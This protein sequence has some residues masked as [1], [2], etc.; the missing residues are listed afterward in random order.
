MSAGTIYSLLER[1]VKN[2]P[3]EVIIEVKNIDNSKNV[4]W[5]K[6]KSAQVKEQVDLVA[7]GLV[8]IGVKKGDAVAIMAHTS[9]SWVVI[10]FALLS[11]GALSIPIYETSSVKQ[12]EYILS[13]SAIK[14]V[15]TEDTILADRVKEASANLSDFEG[16]HIIDNT[17]ED[18][19]SLG[20][21]AV[22]YL[23]Q[24]GKTFDDKIDLEVLHQAVSPDDLAT[25]VYTSGS[26]GN[27]KGV[28]LTHQNFFSIVEGGLEGMPEL[29]MRD[30]A[31]LLLFLPLAH[32]FARY[33]EFV[34]IGG[35]IC[36]GLVSDVSTLIQDLGDFKPTFVLGVPRIFEKV[37]NASS[38][39]AGEG[40]QG[41]LFK[42]AVRTAIEYSKAE[43]NIA[44]NG[45]HIPG[46]LS[47]RHGFYSKLVYPKLHQ[48]LGGQVEYIVSGGA[49]IDADLAHFFT[50]AGLPILEGYGL[51][52]TSAPALVNRVHA[53]KIGT[54]GQPLPGVQVKTADDGEI[55]IKSESVMRGYHNMPEINKEVLNDGW[56]GTGDLGEL[57]ES[58][59]LRITGR[60]KDIIVTAGGKNVSPSALEEAIKTIP[61]ISEAVVIGDRKPFI[62]AIIT[63]DPDNLQYFLKT[64]NLDENLSIAQAKQLPLVINEIENAVAKANLLV[65]RAESIRKYEILD[66]PFTEDNGQLTASMKVRRNEVI[67][68][69][70][71][72]INNKIYNS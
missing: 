37:L 24:L 59:H 41:K 7:K 15:F 34:S 58:G 39:K 5:S 68:I 19:H 33:L 29:L 42:A 22:D 62:A 16:V 35:T 14:F 54:V 43:Q 38:Q 1:R 60:K 67:R 27:P 8:Q 23:A 64:H 46:G 53:N 10:D 47:A 51:T 45:G 44:V 13:D 2:D 49:P 28:E 26:T 40:L 31:R 55:L 70:Q 21:N 52:E 61:V 65:S 66:D 36:A 71:D 18:G 57:L 17:D 25:I 69:H 48:A 3:N 6:V 11:I 50:G 20:Q 72:L 12:V 63:L 9:Y 30:G 56:I 4:T 32:V